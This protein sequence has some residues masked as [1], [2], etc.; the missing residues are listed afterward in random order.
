MQS[1]VAACFERQCKHYVGVQRTEVGDL[2]VCAAYPQGIPLEIASGEDDHTTPRAD[3]N[4]IQFEI[5]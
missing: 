1:R 4:G 3:D 5:K 2:N